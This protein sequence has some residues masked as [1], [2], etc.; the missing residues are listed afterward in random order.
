MSLSYTDLEILEKNVAI[1]L[2]AIKKT[3]KG[4]IIQEAKEVLKKEI[5]TLLDRARVRQ[6]FKVVKNTYAVTSED[7]A[8]ASKIK[9]KH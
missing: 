4:P 7:N 6:D 2:D 8:Q 1:S 5:E 3:G 9:K